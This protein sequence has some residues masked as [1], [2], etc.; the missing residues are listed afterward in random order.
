[1]QPRD[2]GIMQRAAVAGLISEQSQ[3][4]TS[5]SL[6]TAVIHVFLMTAVPGMSIC[7]THAVIVL[8]GFGTSDDR[9]AH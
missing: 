7:W 4:N 5:Q 9:S 8:A 6:P 1:M 2:V 3:C